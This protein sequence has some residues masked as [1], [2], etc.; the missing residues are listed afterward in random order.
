MRTLKSPQVLEEQAN[1]LREIQ[2]LKAAA[3]LLA[4]GKPERARASEA[5]LG[6]A[7]TRQDQLLPETLEMLLAWAT[8]TNEPN[9][10]DL[11]DDGDR[12]IYVWQQGAGNP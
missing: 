6:L 1:L 12:L 7:K 3:H 10:P 8:H 5:A 2:H 11:S 4:L 9:C